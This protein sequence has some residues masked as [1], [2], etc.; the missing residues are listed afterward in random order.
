MLTLAHNLILRSR[1]NKP[2]TTHLSF[3]PIISLKILLLVL[4][5]T[6]AH[7]KIPLKLLLTAW[8]SFI[9]S[10]ATHIMWH[11][12]RASSMHTK[13]SLHGCCP[14]IRALTGPREMTSNTYQ[15]PN[16]NHMC[17]KEYKRRNN[18]RNLHRSTCHLH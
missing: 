14:K 16:S 15:W 3:K 1:L 2:R 12:S 8:P 18:Y 4:I 13:K 5:S 6:W 10:Q 11:T 17:Q 7:C 9:D